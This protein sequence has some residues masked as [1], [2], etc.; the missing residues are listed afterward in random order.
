MSI[1][2]GYTGNQYYASDT[3]L[4]W[5]PDLNPPGGSIG[6]IYHLPPQYLGRVTMEST[7]RSFDDPQQPINCYNISVASAGM[8]V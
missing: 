5:S 3:G 1:D 4:V 7:L 2:C 6:V 8:L